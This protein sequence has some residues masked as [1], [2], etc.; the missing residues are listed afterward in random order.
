MQEHVKAVL[1]GSGKFVAYWQRSSGRPWTPVSEVP[2]KFPAS[3]FF[4]TEQQAL[5][6]ARMAR[7]AAFEKERADETPSTE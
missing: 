2:G 3:K 5:D 4:D 7:E 1:R 6:A